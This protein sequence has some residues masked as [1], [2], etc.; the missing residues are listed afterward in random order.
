MTR[1]RR[2]GRSPSAYSSVRL[3]P[4]VSTPLS[5][6]T[7]M[8]SGS[9]PGRSKR[10]STS[11]LRRMLSIGMTDRL[12]APPSV[13][14][15]TRCASLSN[16]RVKGSY[17]VSS[18]AV[19]LHLSWIHRSRLARFYLRRNLTF[20]LEV[21]NSARRPLPDALDDGPVR[22]AAA[23]AHGLQAEPAAGALQL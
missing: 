3:A 15:N 19:H 1:S 7:S 12:W 6:V 5:T 22:L 23:L 16:S 4:T 20:F 11:S 17:E 18:T 2:Y 9:I 21:C 8:D 10:S 13:V 14:P